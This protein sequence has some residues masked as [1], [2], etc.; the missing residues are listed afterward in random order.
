MAI[1]PFE[2][3]ETCETAP[4]RSILEGFDPNDLVVFDRY[5]C[6]YLML[7]MLNLKDATATIDAMGC[8][9]DIAQTAWTRATSTFWGSKATMRCSTKTSGCLWMMR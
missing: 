9:K 7:A 2:G 8:Q 1:G 6:S 5:Y 4:L 3:K